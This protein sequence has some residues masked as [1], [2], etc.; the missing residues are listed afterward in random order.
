MRKRNKKSKP[1]QKSGQNRSRT[2]TV[3]AKPDRRA[4]LNRLAGW[5]VGIAVLGAF[6]AW[7]VGTVRARMDENDLS[8]VGQGVPT[9]V[10]VHDTTCSVCRTLMRETRATLADMDQDRLHY[11][12]AS[13]QTGQGRSFAARFGADKSTLLL[14]DRRGTLKQRLVGHRPEEQLKPI[15]ERLSNHR[16]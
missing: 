15:F 6:G 10:Q 16:L 9:I 8:T 13:L 2:K 1:S 14:F 4:A 11:R 3:P 7:S 5:G 12:V